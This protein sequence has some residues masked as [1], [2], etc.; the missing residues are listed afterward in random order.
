MVDMV[1]WQ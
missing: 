1:S